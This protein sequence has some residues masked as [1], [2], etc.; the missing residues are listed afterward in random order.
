MAHRLVYATCAHRVTHG[1]MHA[2]GRPL[3][4]VRLH[5]Q[6]AEVVQR[7]LLDD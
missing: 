1:E 2:S 4:C 6:L 3:P 7:Y 5:R